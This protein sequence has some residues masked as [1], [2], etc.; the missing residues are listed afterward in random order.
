M[1]YEQHAST[2]YIGEIRVRIRE[3]RVEDLNKKAVIIFPEDNDR[4]TKF[5]NNKK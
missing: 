4:F 2:I 5:H 3:I 1:R